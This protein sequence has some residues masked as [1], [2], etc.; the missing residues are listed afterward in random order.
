MLFGRGCGGLWGLWIG[1]SGVDVGD[2][3]GCRGS[4][5]KCN[6]WKTEV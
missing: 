4:G 3:A 5:N 1:V 6:I 2:G